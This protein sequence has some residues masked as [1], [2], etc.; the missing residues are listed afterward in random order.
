MSF[1]FSQAKEIGVT[2]HLSKLFCLFLIWINSKQLLR[3]KNQMYFSKGPLHNFRVTCFSLKILISSHNQTL[4]KI[5]GLSCSFCLSKLESSVCKNNLGFKFQIYIFT[6]ELVL[7]SKPQEKVLILPG[8][9]TYDINR[10]WVTI[11]VV[12]TFF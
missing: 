5:I 11:N 1:Y 10:C 6:S 4:V 3:K 8:K 2:H 12:F 9:R 7:L